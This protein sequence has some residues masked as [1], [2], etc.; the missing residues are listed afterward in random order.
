MLLVREVQRSEKDQR[1]SMFLN[2][3]RWI[4]FPASVPFCSAVPHPSEP[5]ILFYL[6]PNSPSYLFSY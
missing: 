6:L 3:V 4:D 1:E 5:F 2:H